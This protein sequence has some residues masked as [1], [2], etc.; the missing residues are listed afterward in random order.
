M[1]DD[2]TKYPRRFSLSGLFIYVGVVTVSFGIIQWSFKPQG[3]ATDLLRF[4]LGLV[5]LF[6]STAYCIGY[7][8]G[9]LGRALIGLAIALVVSIAVLVAQSI[10]LNQVM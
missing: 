2:R 5:L 6:G 7:L 4:H 3:L 1:T 9:G 8:F 10:L